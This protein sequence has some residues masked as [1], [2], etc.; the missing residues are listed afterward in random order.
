MPAGGGAHATW[1][2]R[3]RCLFKGQDPADLLR[4]VHAAARGQRTL[5]AELAEGIIDELTRISHAST[6]AGSASAS[7]MPGSTEH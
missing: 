7:C 6:R 3:Q 5:S 1:L 4:A 2:I